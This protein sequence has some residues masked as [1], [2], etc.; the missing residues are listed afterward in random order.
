ML[1][2]FV[3]FFFPRFSK[4]SKK[5]KKVGEDRQTDNMKTQKRTLLYYYT[6]I[7][8]LLYITISILFVS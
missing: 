2:I 1:E 8:I 5:S 4:K 6:G 7:Y 3:E